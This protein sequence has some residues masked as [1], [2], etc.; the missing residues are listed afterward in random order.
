MAAAYDTTCLMTTVRNIA[1]GTRTFSFLPPHGRTLAANEEFSVYGDIFAATA[2]ASRIASK[3]HHDALVDAIASDNKTLEVLRTPA[4]IFWDRN[5][6]TTHVL[7]LESGAV[8]VRDTC[9]E[10]DLTSS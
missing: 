3:R 8:V 10:S 9:M 2:R 5:L 1:G 4:P 7:S 6:G